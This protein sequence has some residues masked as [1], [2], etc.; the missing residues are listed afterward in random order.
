MSKTYEQIVAEQGWSAQSQLDLALQYIDNQQDKAAWLDFLSAQAQI[1][2]DL[3]HE[4]QDTLPQEP[5]ASAPARE[6]APE[7]A[8]D[9]DARE[10]LVP[11]LSQL[12]EDLEAK[13]I[14]AYIVNKYGVVPLRWMII[15]RDGNLGTITYD[16]FDGYKVSFA[17]RPSRKYGSGLLVEN[18]AGDVLGQAEVA[19]GDTYANFATGSTR[20][21]NDGWRHFAWARDQIARVSGS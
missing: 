2:N 4:A 10:R 1:E 19:V 18:P 7:R 11:E 15:E 5:Q 21:D 12:L 16:N 20:L 9:T 17:T 3:D 6:Q 14:T 13:G 8:L